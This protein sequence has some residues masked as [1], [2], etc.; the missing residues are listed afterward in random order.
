MIRMTSPVFSRHSRPGS[1]TL[2]TQ[3]ERGSG[4]WSHRGNSRA[5]ENRLEMVRVTPASISD[6]LKLRRKPLIGTVAGMAQSCC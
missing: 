6:T 3:K 4:A 5:G 2:F 1:D